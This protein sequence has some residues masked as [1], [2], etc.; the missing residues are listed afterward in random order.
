MNFSD[1]AVKQAR[2]LLLSPKTIRENL[3]VRLVPKNAFNYRLSVSFGSIMVDG[4][5]LCFV[6]ASVA[7][8]ISLKINSKA[9]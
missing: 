2:K 8:I 5:R 6:K 7:N 1:E 4:L 9:S 3:K